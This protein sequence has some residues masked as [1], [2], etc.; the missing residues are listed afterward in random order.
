MIG[1]QI[2]IVIDIHSG[3]GNGVAVTV[4]VGVKLDV[5]VCVGGGTSVL[6]L[7]GDG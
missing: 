3:M 4:L 1:G 6:V 5:G 7:V 2:S